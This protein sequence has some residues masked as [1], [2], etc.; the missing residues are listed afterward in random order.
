MDFSWIEVSSKKR[1]LNSP[2][3]SILRKQ[4]K[5]NRYQ[6]SKTVPTNSFEGFEEE[7]DYENN[8][9]RV[10]KTAKPSSILVARINNFS[11][12]SQYL[13]EVASDEYKIEIMNEQI[14]IQP[15]N[16]IAYVSIVKELKSSKKHRV[17]HI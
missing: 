4:P 14:K 2:E 17:L 8:N 13:K 10:E 3:T 1:N 11:S 16:S 15:R 5:M 6:S 12:L 9:I 7:L